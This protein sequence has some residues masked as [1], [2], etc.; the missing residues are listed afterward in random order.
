MI[1]NNFFFMFIEKKEKIGCHF[2]EPG[3][4]LEQIK[5]YCVIK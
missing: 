3:V 5:S 1:Q 4:Q 2:R